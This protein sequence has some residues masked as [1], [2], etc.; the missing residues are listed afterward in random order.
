MLM[1]ATPVAKSTVIVI[2]ERGED[3]DHAIEIEI[4][5]DGE[6]GPDPDP[7]TVT[8][9]GAAVLGLVHVH[10]AQDHVI[11][12]G[13]SVHDLKIVPSDE[14]IGIVRILT[15]SGVR[16]GLRMSLLKMEMTIIAK[17]ILLTMEDSMLK[18]RLS[19][20]KTVN[21]SVPMVPPVGTK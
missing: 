3:R 13:L 15:M 16:L 7:K 9:R 8:V 21:H 1:C 4:V 12:K 14:E 18:S 2:G 17:I 6:E 19:T 11:A 5:R 20:R 10:G